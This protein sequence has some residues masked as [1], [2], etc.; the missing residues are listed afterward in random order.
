MIISHKYKFIFLKTRKTA[1][2]STEFALNDICG[3]Q[4]IVTPV[5]PFNEVK[6]K[7]PPPRN[8]QYRPPIYSSEWPNLISRYVRNGKMPLD[9]YQHMDAW[10]VRRRV[11]RKIWNNYFKFAFDRNPW[12]RE[13]SWYSHQRAQGRFTGTFDEHLKRLPSH[14]V[15]NYEIYSCGGKVAVDFLGRY[16]NL[17]AD[18]AAVMQTIG[19][20]STLGLGQFNSEFRGTS[21]SYQD[22]YDENSRELIRK[23]YRREL[24]LLDYSF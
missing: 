18:L 19:V 20:K 3:D 4:D 7:G 15:G 17:E 16:E 8:Y 14:T 13:I 9:Y 1:S 12:D 11:G 6:R 2:T 21:R 10:R 5:R 23:T 22:W 24:E